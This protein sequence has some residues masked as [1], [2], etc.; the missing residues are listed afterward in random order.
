MLLNP[1]CCM[2]TTQV[3]GAGVRELLVVQRGGDRRWL[4]LLGGSRAVA[5]V[6][7]QNYHESLCQRMAMEEFGTALKG[8]PWVYSSAD[9]RWV[10]LHKFWVLFCTGPSLSAVSVFTASPWLGQCLPCSIF[11][12]EP[13]LVRVAVHTNTLLISSLL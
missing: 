5:S 8:L 12:K 11:S 6:H 7:C 4:M 10:L 1:L 3:G 2:Q 13:P 9:I